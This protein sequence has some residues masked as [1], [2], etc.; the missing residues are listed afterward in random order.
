MRSI[1]F[2]F[3]ALTAVACGDPC[4]KAADRM[5][6]KA[7][8]CGL[9]TDDGGEATD[10][11]EAECTEAAQALAECTADCYDDAPCG[12]FDGSDLEAATAFGECALACVTPA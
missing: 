11:V 6:A 1:L 5:A 4:E 9:T 2:A 8:E 10:D 7:D 3:V 12:A